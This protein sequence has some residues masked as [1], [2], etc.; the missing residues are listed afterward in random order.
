MAT[1]DPN[2]H[3]K[4]VIVGGGAAGL[5]CAE[6]LRQSGFTGEI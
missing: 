4:M 5:N 6:T 1:R 3:T 2:N